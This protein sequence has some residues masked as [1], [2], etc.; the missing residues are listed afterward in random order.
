MQAARRARLLMQTQHSVRAAGAVLRLIGQTINAVGVHYSRIDFRSWQALAPQVLPE[1][2]G[3]GEA[4]AEVAGR[5]SAFFTTAEQ[6]Q[7]LVDEHLRLS[8]SAARDDAG[9][10]RDDLTRAIAPRC[11]E[12]SG[13]T[14]RPRRRPRSARRRS[15][16]SSTPSEPS[17]PGATGGGR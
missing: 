16:R 13:A 17:A 6:I 4:G 11:A 8:F 2:A 9:T 5:L 3:L 12:L 15:P 7:A 1:L 14:K 10:L